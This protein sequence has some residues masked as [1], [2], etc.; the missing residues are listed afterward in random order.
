MWDCQVHA[1][2][3]VVPLLKNALGLSAWAVSVGNL[4]HT[5]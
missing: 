5:A 3:V 2:F 4:K 1:V